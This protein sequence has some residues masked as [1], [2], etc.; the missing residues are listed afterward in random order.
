RAV[1]ERRIARENAILK[2]NLK[3]TY[4][5]WPIVGESAALRRV[6]DLVRKAAP[7]DAAALFTGE[8]GTGKELVAATLHYA[9]PRAEGPFVVANC[10]AL[11]RDALEREL[12]GQPRA[13]GAYA[14]G[15]VRDAEGGSLFLDEVSE[16][17][18]A[19]QV[20]LLRV[21]EEKAIDVRFIAATHRDL[22]AAVE[23]G[24]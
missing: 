23:R 1:K 21:L 19:L 9:S 14:E 22:A 12:F 11:P 7:S 20:R 3:S 2:R 6:Q 24:D 10:G 8:S 16:L 13:A 4:R 15:L 5:S 17:P 18:P